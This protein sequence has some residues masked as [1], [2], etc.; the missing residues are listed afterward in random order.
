MRPVSRAAPPA[1]RAAGV[2][3]RR[4]AADLEQ[5]NARLAAELAELRA[6]HEDLL[7]S[8]QDGVIVL[9]AAGRVISLNQAAEELTGLSDSAARGRALG[10]VFPPP[11]PLAGL[12]SRTLALGRSHADFELDLRRPDGSRRT[13]SAVASQVSG[14]G[15]ECRGAVLVLR[16]LSSVRELEEQVRRSERLAAL[17]VLA[18]GLAHEVRNPLVGVRAAAQLLAKEPAFPAALHEFTGVIIRE[19]DRL[20]RLVDE[21]LSLAGT[22]A[23]RRRPCNVNQMV[24]EALRL[25]GP[26]LQG[27]AV[28]V[29]RRYDP[30]IPVLE[31]D[32]DRLLQVFLNLL[33]NAV[34]AMAG[35]PGALTVSTRFERVAPQCGGRSAAVVEV[36]DRGPGMTPEVQA[37]LFTPF[38]TTKAKGTGLGLPLS[39][40]IVEE[41]EG[42]LELASRPGQGTTARVLLPLAVRRP[43]G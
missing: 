39:L 38:F 15:G 27:G 3:P 19:V 43:G 13:V 6:S 12:V 37:K 30:A 7:S 35:A 42:A 31:A 5:A 41:H 17:G 1:R 9:D 10:E 22:H 24:E 16:D 29:L 40:R 21:L 4:R 14:P 2:R 25:Q 32:P 33:R 34:E 18:A 28:A 8:L 36:E 23:L 20:N 11:A 26:A